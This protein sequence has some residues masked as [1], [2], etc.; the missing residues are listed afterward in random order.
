[1]DMEMIERVYDTLMGNL[2]DEHQ[3]P[4][5]ENAFSPG[6][7]CDVLYSQIFRAYEEICNRE[8]TQEDDDVECIINSFLEICR[9]IGFQMFEYGAESAKNKSNPKD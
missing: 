1:M 4:G 3:I 8:Q 6:K 9:I 2:T 7:P 5:I